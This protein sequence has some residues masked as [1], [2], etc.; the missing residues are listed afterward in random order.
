MPEM[1]TWTVGETT[2]EI[3]DAKAREAIN[4]INTARENGEFKGED[5][6][7]AYA[8]AQDGGYT[9]TEEEFAEKLAG[10]D[11]GGVS[12]WNDLTDKPFGVEKVNPYFDN[13]LTGRTVLPMA[14]G[15]NLVKITDYVLT[16]AECIGAVMT[17][18]RAGQEGTEAITENGVVDLTA[19]FGISC[20]MA[21]PDAYV[22]YG[23]P[24][25]AVVREPGTVQGLKASA[26]TYYLSEDNTPMYV[27]HFSALENL[28][29]VQKMDAKF[30]DAEWMATKTVSKGDAVLE[31]TELE[32]QSNITTGNQECNNSGTLLLEEGKTYIVTWDGNEYK[33][34]C[35]AAY[36]GSVKI[37]FLGNAALSGEDGFAET[38]DPFFI[39][40]VQDASMWQVSCYD[41]G[42]NHTCSIHEAEAV[43]NILPEEFLPDMTEKIN[44]LIDAKLGVIENGSY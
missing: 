17:I 3:V 37:C 42:N 12:S 10:E 23:M 18:N 38:N 36:A 6:K 1:K 34:V 11:S 26:G 2:Y 39:L 20:F 30:I 32:F 13:D 24:F 35:S 16:K 28:E 25:V 44:A 14:E 21:C 41:D 22:S 4:E 15:V 9:G 43:P 29:I 40:D 8:Y 31:E 33:C 5:G 19:Q 27:S 7:S